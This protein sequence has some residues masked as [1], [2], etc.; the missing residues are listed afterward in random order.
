MYAVAFSPDGARL[1]AG[2]FDGQVRFYNSSDCTLQKAIVPVPIAASTSTAGGYAMKLLFWITMAAACAAQPLITDLQPR[3]VQKGRPFTLTV[4][5]RDLV[6]G[7]RIESILPA[8]FTPLGPEKGAMGGASF[9]VEPA[10]DVAVGVYS[11]RVVTPEGISNVQLFSIG[12][13]PE[14]IEDESRAGAL[15]NTNDTIE[16]AQSAAFRIRDHE[17]QTRRPRARCVPHQRQRRREARHRSGSSPLPAQ[18]S[19]LSSNCEDQSGNVLARSE[20]AS[21]LGLDARLEF[22]FPK[23]GY[24]YVVLHDARYSVQ[25]A[26]FYRLKIGTYSYPQEIFPLGGRRGETVTSF[27]GHPDGCSRP[28]KGREGRSPDLHQPSRQPCAAAS[29]S[30][31]ATIPEVIATRVRTRACP[32]SRS[33]DGWPRPAK[34]TATRLN[35]TPRSR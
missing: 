6:E 21:F 9:L 11:I 17:W 10:A 35:V 3:G 19:I 20:D 14:Y 27:I 29:V 16:N 34:W 18:P 2:G 33:M 7:A 24:Y 28:S 31:S 25:T 26:N 23:D 15:P 8:A 12:T 1:A 30:L 22:T 32:Q 5:G 13:F 4:I